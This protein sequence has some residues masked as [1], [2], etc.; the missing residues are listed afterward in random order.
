[1]RERRDSLSATVVAKVRREG[2]VSLLREGP[3]WGVKNSIRT[4]QLASR[5]RLRRF[6][7]RRAGMVT[8]PDP[9]AT[10]EV[11]PAAVTHIVPQSQ[12]EAPRLLLG[13]V[14]GGD[15]DRDLPRIEDQPKY[16]ACRARVEGTAWADTGI[17]DHLAAELERSEADAIEHGC[18]SRAALRERYED[19]RETLYQ[20][21][22]DEGYDRSLSPVCC[23]LHVG[24]DGRLLFG[25]GGRHR[26]YLS[27][28]LDIGPVPVQVLCRH[29]DWQAVREAVAT[30]DHPD[31][32]P[33]DVRAHLG[34]PDL[35]ELPLARPAGQE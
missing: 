14:R 22:L 27:R 3:V 17:I 21:L 34:H 2:P 18:D 24:R 1:M 7:Y 5:R 15:W 26:F 6:R 11:D 20:S 29:R 35:R 16:R 9:T 23:R 28:L 32:L 4:L 13:T 25:G 12:F 33:D 19:E 31:E 30:V 8:V 10:I